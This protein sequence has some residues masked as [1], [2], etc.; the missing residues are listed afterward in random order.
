MVIKPIASGSSGN[1]YYVSDGRSEILIEAGISVPKIEQGLWGAG[2]RLS[3]I[4]ACLVSHTHGDH[5][6]SAFALTKRGV[7]VYAN[8][9][10]LEKHDIR[11]YR[12]KQLSAYDSARVNAEKVG[13]SL[14][15]YAFEVPHDVPTLGFFVYSNYSNEKLCYVSDAMYMP[16]DFQGI[17]HLMIEANYD[18]ERMSLNAAEG[19]IDRARMRRTAY[20]HMSIDSAV[21]AV[22]RMDRT[23]LKEIWLLHL[24]ED[25]AE[26]DFK[27]KMQEAAGCEVYVA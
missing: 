24:S 22:E 8:Q 2:T 12:A 1:C 4:D 9:D 23:K 3:R 25:N 26:G 19:R 20:S 18:P 15:V 13:T 6:K 5:A 7:D 17:T 10:T 27:R 14:Y 16:Y 21:L 11:G